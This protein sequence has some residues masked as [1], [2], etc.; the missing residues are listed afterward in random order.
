MF[1]LPFVQRGCVHVP[2]LQSRDCR[3]ESEVDNSSWQATL[4]RPTLVVMEEA[5]GTYD[6]LPPAAI[7]ETSGYCVPA[8]SVRRKSLENENEY[9]TLP[10]GT[11]TFSATLPEGTHTF[12]A[13]SEF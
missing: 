9:A 5:G 2:G 6:A 13:S 12:S 8:A 7:A 4:R 10:E 1:G 3:G 11:H